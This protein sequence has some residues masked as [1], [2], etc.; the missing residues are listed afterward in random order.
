MVLGGQ[1][2]CYRYGKSQ[3]CT[4]VKGP[5]KKQAGPQLGW[6]L[7]LKPYLCIEALDHVTGDSCTCDSLQLD[8]RHV[9]SG[10]CESCNSASASPPQTHYIPNDSRRPARDLFYSPEMESNHLVPGDMQ[11]LFATVNV[12]TDAPPMQA[13]WLPFCRM[14]HHI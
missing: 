14:Q 5:K 13:T 4:S 8:G 11:R 2:C 1:Y 7:C 12:A 6:R 10:D 3:M 9:L